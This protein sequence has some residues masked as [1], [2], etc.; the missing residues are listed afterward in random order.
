MKIVYIGQYAYSMDDFKEIFESFKQEHDIGGM[1]KEE[2]MCLEWS[3][4]SYL[5][6]PRVRSSF[7]LGNAFLSIFDPAFAIYK[8]MLEKSEEQAEDNSQNNIM[9]IEDLYSRYPRV[10]KSYLEDVAKRME[11]KGRGKPGARD[12]IFRKKVLSLLNSLSVKCSN[13]GEMIPKTSKKCPYC[14]QPIAPIRGISEDPFT[15]LKIRYAKGEI[16]K[17]EY[18]EIKK[19]LESE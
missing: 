4:V 2:F 16:T 10:V 9:A 18:E 19:T 13:C 7:G 11:E 5:G 15:I 6:K 8:L 17:E 1:S 3:L 14:N 12:I